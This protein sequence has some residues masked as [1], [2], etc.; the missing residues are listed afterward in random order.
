MRPGL[1]WRKTMSDW[2]THKV[3]DPTALEGIEHDR[4]HD[5]GPLTRAHAPAFQNCGWRFMH[6]A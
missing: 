6:E 4:H 1:L 2:R 5:D 3:N